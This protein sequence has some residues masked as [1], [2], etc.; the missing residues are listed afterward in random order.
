MRLRYLHEADEAEDVKPARR[1]AVGGF[2]RA[3]DQD[4]AVGMTHNR[5]GHVAHEGS[6]QPAEP[7]ATHHDQV[8]T[9]VLGQVD[10]RLVPLLAK[11]EVGDG[12]GAARLLDLPNLFV[13]YLLGVAPDGLASRLGVG[14]EL[15]V[16]GLG[17]RAP[18]DDDV[19][20]S[21]SALGQ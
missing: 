8:R 14:E 20:A 13:E 2:N 4:R 1:V 10:Y 11:L 7:P 9:D 19:E 6:P 5:V 15:V 21:P 12:D 3:H 17:E 16:D 18:D